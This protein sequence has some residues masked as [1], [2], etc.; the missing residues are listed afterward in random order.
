MPPPDLTPGLRRILESQSGPPQE[1]LTPGLRRLLSQ[2]A[3]PEQAAK[4]GAGPEP[5]TPGLQRLLGSAG[6]TTTSTPAAG[7]RERAGGAVGKAL[8]LS[9]HRERIETLAD[10]IEPVV[11]DLPPPA[12]LERA[13]RQV[14][15]QRFPPEERRKMLGDISE[16]QATLRHLQRLPAKTAVMAE[17][18]GREPEVIQR[19]G[20]LEN[21]RAP[22][23]EWE[24]VSRAE[25]EG[26]QRVKAAE[27]AE[28]RAWENRGGWA[29]VGPR[30]WWHLFDVI[31]LPGAVVRQI[32]SP[33]HAAFS[34]RLSQSEWWAKVKKAAAKEG[35]SGWEILTA[36]A[37]VGYLPGAPISARV[38][39]LQGLADLPSVVRG[40][41]TPED[42]LDR[43]WEGFKGGLEGSEELAAGMALDPLSWL[44]VAG[45]RGAKG[46]AEAARVIGPALERRILQPMIARGATPEKIAATRQRIAA[47]SKS[48]TDRLVRETSSAD[49]PELAQRAAQKVL[50]PLEG[51]A[52]GVS[53]R[54][55]GPRMTFL[56]SGEARLGVPFAE[57]KLGVPLHRLPGL[58]KLPPHAGK[59][60]IKA[61]VDTTADLATRGYNALAGVLK[62]GLKQQPRGLWE[63]PTREAWARRTR[64]QA[65]DTRQLAA[66]E[67][68]AGVVALAAKGLPRAARE[69]LIG[70]GHE[71]DYSYRLL[72]VEKPGLAG[73]LEAQGVGL[74]VEPSMLDEGDEVA[75]LGR[76]QDWLDS[77]HMSREEYVALRHGQLDELRD[78][79]REALAP[80]G[81]HVVRPRPGFGDMA[82]TKDPGA[83]FRKHPLNLD[84][85]KHISPLNKFQDLMDARLDPYLRRLLQEGG[86]KMTVPVTELPGGKWRSL[87]KS[88]KRERDRKTQLA[89]AVLAT[90]AGDTKQ[91]ARLAQKHAAVRSALS[92][93]PT[94]PADIE[95]A[96]TSAFM[97]R[98]SAET[99]KSLA[100]AIPPRMFADLKKLAEAD[101]HAARLVRSAGIAFTKRRT[102]MSPAEWSQVLAI[103]ND[104]R[105]RARLNVDPVEPNAN[106]IQIKRQGGTVEHWEI[107]PQGRVIAEATLTPLERRFLAAVDDFF[108]RNLKRLQDAGVLEPGREARH[109]LTG[110]YFP[111]QYSALFE[112]AEAIKTP[113]GAGAFTGSRGPMGGTPYGRWLARGGEKGTGVS[114]TLDPLE[115]IP[116]YARRES[117]AIAQQRLEDEMLALY[118]R[119]P[120]EVQ[121]LGGG[122]AKDFRWI[123][124]ERT[125]PGGSKKAAYLDADLHNIIQGTFDESIDSWT[126]A[127]MTW[128]S[129]GHNVPE[130]VIQSL[131][132][133]EYARN[134]FK[135][136]NL[137]K[138]PAYHALNTVSDIIQASLAG[139]NNPLG[140]LRQAEAVLA[141][142]PHGI[143]ELR[144]VPSARLLDDAQREGFALH[145]L[146]PRTDIS[147]VGE[148]R[149]GKLSEQLQEIAGDAPG[150]GRLAKKGWGKIDVLGKWGEK[151]AA[152]WEDRMRLATY[153]DRRALGYSS[154]DAA[155][156]VR[157]HHL[158][159]RNRSFG[160]NVARFFIPFAT[161]AAKSPKIAAAAI[162]K[163]PGRIAAIPRALEAFTAGGSS[164]DP[165]G[166]GAQPQAEERG[167]LYA[168]G[169]T[170]QRIAGAGLEAFGSP[171]LSEGYG[172]SI[173]PR[174]VVSESA[175]P[176]LMAL[177]NN[178]NLIGQMFDPLI[179]AFVENRSGVDLYT[180]RPTTSVLREQGLGNEDLGWLMRYV[181]PYVLSPLFAQALNDAVFYTYGARGEQAPINVVSY[182]RPVADAPARAQAARWWSKFIPFPVYVT[183]PVTRVQSAVQTP[184]ARAL[185]DTAKDVAGYDK[186]VRREAAK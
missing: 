119:T 39:I 124:Y 84:P 186:G 155:A 61:A 78:I 46:T 166:Y 96:L 135:R 55:F 92:D 112:R 49:S 98:A 19:M 143:P 33:E 136:K 129:S 138:V 86:L 168:V 146:D 163:H 164:G 128:R 47:V 160:L 102:E 156:F 106:I 66:L 87:E 139:V 167:P 173:L 30:K 94:D 134:A 21:L 54:A 181:A 40:E 77:R 107:A 41:A 85:Y 185:R 28:I 165:R 82:T 114:A 100:A 117:R 137:I 110:K 71:P 91:L 3:P 34:G 184:P 105:V 159:Y 25:A 97:E 11:S 125:L 170:G 37:K 10:R 32:L 2:T 89:K 73:N 24:A 53:E 104:A 13:R 52:P 68:E 6:P 12:L 132:G 161:W 154:A 140:R 58:S 157:L 43:M 183:S 177:Q 151:Y 162:V 22:G 182:H 175:Q 7:W 88:I 9:A 93:G 67:E 38:S 57:E 147:G 144:E 126:N 5:L 35:F 60:A 23:E 133:L 45:L 115:V 81:K 153:L 121:A 80:T 178:W 72:R 172:V 69:E 149:V 26:A 171:P 59:R 179:K 44:P 141:N 42:V 64:A 20:A 113:S 15:E 116:R 123:K 169:P 50:G 4:P 127:A 31:D 131:R 51:I 109:F 62:M 120:Q 108:G 14:E 103:S 29:S 36:L 158:D 145:I 79:A 111:R 101:P 56:E 65:L 148:A 8:G 17:R 90:Q 95:R 70:Y 180:G 16:H 83:K 130:I 176:A 152:W 74:S 118:G 48:L 174:E 63:V 142:R 122:M 75:V 150:V 1:E 76:T 99:L 27:E 18:H